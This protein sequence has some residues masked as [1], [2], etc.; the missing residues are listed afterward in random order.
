MKVAIVAFQIASAI[1]AAFAAWFWFRS[2]SA[3]PPPMTWKGLGEL[4]GWLAETARQ[5]RRA[6][7]FAG[8][9]AALGAIAMALTAG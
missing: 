6:A 4:E 7:C 9:S 8:A 1:S 3:A 5:N 2:A